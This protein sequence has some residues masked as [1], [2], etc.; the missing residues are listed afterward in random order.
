MTDYPTR[1]SAWRRKQT[2]TKLANL[3]GIFITVI[4]LLALA[5]GFLRSFSL[6]KYLG[7]SSW[8]GKSSQ[9]VAL[10][11]QPGSILIFQPEPKRLVLAK[12]G[13]NLHFATGNP[14]NPVQDLASLFGAGDG[15]RMIQ[16]LSSIGRTSIKNYLLFKEAIPA[17]RENLERFFKKFASLA[18]PLSILTGSWERDI[19]NTNLTRKDLIS[20]WWQVKALG[21]GDLSLVDLGVSEKLVLADDRQVLGVDSVSL[22][23]AIGQYLENRK[24][25]EEGMAVSIQNASGVAG[26]GGLAAD[27]VASVG[28]D[29]KRLETV[30]GPVA[31]SQILADNTSYTVLYLAKI[32]ECGIKNVPAADGEITVII[33]ADFAQKYLF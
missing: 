16:V 33:G 23:K 5:N 25:V 12:F 2:Q 7:D 32:F 4:L 20:L 30:A 27:F 22:Q 28:G 6:G 24:L 18:T 21:V 8:D 13:Q 31:K 9:V 10:N 26:A 1:S 19:K 15:Q 17:D 14:Q 3:A 29:V 11:W